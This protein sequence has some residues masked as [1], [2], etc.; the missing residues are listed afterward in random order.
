[1]CLKLIDCYYYCSNYSHSKSLSPSI[2]TFSPLHKVSFLLYNPLLLYLMYASLPL[3]SSLFILLLLS[4]S[5]IQTFKFSNCHSSIQTI[6]MV[7]FLFL[8]YSYPSSHISLIDSLSH[9]LLHLNHLPP[10]FYS[11]FL[12]ILPLLISLCP[13]PPHFSILIFLGS[14][15]AP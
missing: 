5:S 15:C 12:L 11:F 1:M 4:I 10:L 9:L 13:Y 3:S 14:S 6:S 7:T 8:S 2:D